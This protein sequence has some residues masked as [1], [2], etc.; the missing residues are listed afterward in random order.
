[1]QPVQVHG[2]QVLVLGTIDLDRDVV[3]IVGEGWQY[4][5][6]SWEALTLFNPCPAYCRSPVLCTSSIFH[7]LTFICILRPCN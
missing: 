6:K 7:D 1:V 4:R 5:C 2:A 3:E